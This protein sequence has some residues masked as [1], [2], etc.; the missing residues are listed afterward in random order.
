M[1]P[2]LGDDQYWNIRYMVYHSN[3]INKLELENILGIPRSKPTFREMWV[4]HY[5][6]KAYS[7]D[8]SPKQSVKKSI[9]KTIVDRIFCIIKAII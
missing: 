4:I 2:Y 3:Y 5:V 9:W 7:F 8:H 1:N 6:T